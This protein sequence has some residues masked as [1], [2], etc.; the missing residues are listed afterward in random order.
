MKLSTNSADSVQ[1]N[2]VSGC[3]KRNTK[4]FTSNQKNCIKNAYLFITLNRGLAN[5]IC[6]LSAKL[7]SSIVPILYNGSMPKS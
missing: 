6:I 4:E 7:I 1:Y 2:N 3:E 5:P